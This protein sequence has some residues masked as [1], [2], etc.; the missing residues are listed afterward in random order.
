M[1]HPRSQCGRVASDE[2][3]PRVNGSGENLLTDRN[4]HVHSQRARVAAATVAVL[5]SLS[6]S[7]EESP[8]AIAG[9]AQA[10]EAH[11]PPPPLHITYTERREPCL[12]RNPLRNAYFG[13][14]HVHTRYSM[15]ANIWDVRGTPDDAYRFARGEPLALPPYDAEG[16]AQRTTQLDRPLDFAAVTDHASFL[17]EVS[18]CTT[19]GNPVFDS[20]ECRTFR[21]E[22]AVD[23]PLGAVGARMAGIANIAASG[24][25]EALCGPDGAACRREL[26]SVWKDIQN[27]AERAYD[28]SSQCGFTAFKGYEYTA[29]PNLSKVHRNIIFRNAVVP[30]RP[31]TWVDVPEAMEMFRA[32]ESQCLDAGTRCDVLSLPHNSNLSNGQIFTVGYKGESMAEQVAQATLKARI[33][34]LVEIMQIKGD[35]ECRN[36]MYDVLGGTDELCDFEKWRPLDNPP[37][38]CKEGTGEGALIGRGCVS[39]VDYVR[40]ALIEGL[41]EAERI[42][43]NPYKLGITASTDAHIANPGDVD[44][45]T[46]EGWSGVSDDSAEE[47]LG[48]GDGIVNNLKANPGGLVGV[49]SEENSRDALFAAMQRRETFGTSG[50]RIQPRFFGGWSFDASLCNA[51][52]LIAKSY[53]EGVA[54][55]GDLPLRPSDHAKPTFLVSALRDPGTAEL[56]GGLLQRI[57]IIKGWV[58]DE[59]RMRQDIYDVAG[60]ADNGASVDLDTCEPQGEGFDALCSVWTDPDFD[61]NRRALYY[62]RVVENPSCRWNQHQ[63]IALPES[64]RPPACDAPGTTRVIQERAW[65]SPIWFEE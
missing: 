37:E 47:R 20:D 13:D 40:Y 55:G 60:N 62:A 2:T 63:C 43:V 56:P 17:A 38:D 21:G 35:S 54:M 33:E 14:L 26:T 23:G 36:G 31:I 49:W 32:L 24:R 19:P 18:I 3:R 11:T 22:F 29:T 4:P 46:Y 28:R 10:I 34:P 7:T 50:P 48:G 42:G 57:Q 16:V 15:D 64:E 6:C 30:E 59:G 1:R 44:E 65:T 52:D 39:R 27:A 41:R 9:S 45:R 25:K 58:D 8:G 53:A 12:D 51:P 61:P 5:L